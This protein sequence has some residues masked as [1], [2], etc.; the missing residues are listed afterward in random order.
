M[1]LI[2]EFFGVA[3]KIESLEYQEFLEYAKKYLTKTV[4]SIHVCIN[5]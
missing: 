4:Y 1:G 3:N 2:F 5:F